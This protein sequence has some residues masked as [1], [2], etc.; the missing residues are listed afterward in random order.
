M[1]RKNRLL[2]PAFLQIW[3]LTR[4]TK[5]LERSRHPQ[6]GNGSGRGDDL[7]KEIEAYGAKSQSRF[8]EERR[9]PLWGRAYVLILILFFLGAEWYLRR[10]WGMV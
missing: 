2:F 10:K 1:S 6:E 3:M 8:T 4:T 9:V 5:S 7:L